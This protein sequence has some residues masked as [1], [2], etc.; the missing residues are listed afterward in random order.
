MKKLLV[1]CFLFLAVLSLK[2]QVIINEVMYAPAANTEKEW[3]EIYNSSP[4][5]VNLMNWKWKDATTTYRTITTVST[6]LNP[7]QY[8]IVCQDTAAV[9]QYHPGLTGVLFQTTWNPLNNDNDDL[10]IYDGS[11]LSVDSLHYTSSWG[12]ASGNSLERKNPLAPTNNSS[13]WGTSIDVQKSSPNRLNSLTP[14]NYDLYLSSFTYI[15]A[16]PKAGDTLNLTFQIKNIGL[17]NASNYSLNIYKNPALDSIAKTSDLIYTQNFLTALNAGD[18]VSFTYKLAIDS[19][20]KQFIGVAAYSQ[21]NDTTNNKLIKNINVGGNGPVVSS[22]III[23]EIMYHPLSS[24]ECEWVELYNTTSS[25]INIRN[26]KIS[27]FSTQ[28]SPVT[29]TANDLYINANDYIVIAKNNTILNAH[30]QIDS[31]K[32]SYLSNL[33]T[34]NDDGDVVTIYNS[35]NTILDQVSYKSSWGGNTARNSLER[36]SSSR[37][38]ADSTNWATSM[39]CEYSSPTRI[40]SLASVT[41]YS[42]ND[43]VVNEIMFDP[44]TSDCEWIEFYNPTGKSLNLSG[45]KAGV[46]SN[47]YNLYDTCNLVITPGQYVVLAYDTTVYNRYDYLR[48]TDPSRKVIFNKSLSLTNSGAMV[49]VMDALNNVIDSVY[50]D[51][52]WHNNNIPDTKGYSLERINPLLGSNDKSNW[53]SCTAP[54]GGTPGLKNSIFTVNAINSTSVS[55]SPNPF[56]PD[57]DG[58][59]DFTIIKYQLKTG[60]SQLRVKVFDIKGRIVRTLL[61]NRLSGSEGQIIFDGKNDN[62]EKLRIGIYI[63]YIE[64]LNDMGGVIEHT[65]TTVVVAAKL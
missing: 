5:A 17:N 27:D 54:S 30:M 20:L 59:E 15:P 24:L 56:S 42:R 58:F 44:L 32:I 63:L 10:I 47:F 28:S 16:S 43:L 19:G 50:Y 22:G 65:K 7:G 45:W 3:F 38:S 21:D 12:G 8:A 60:I 14:K 1:F 55:V 51:P 39:D 9:R 35:S 64:A 33:P 61:N 29:I 2:A 49:R 6:I 4:A 13:N 11:G 31:A 52:K 34:L 40:N 46:S 18:S 48:T 53:N 25:A 26:W 41:G 36:I 37:P 62:G 57:G 23:N